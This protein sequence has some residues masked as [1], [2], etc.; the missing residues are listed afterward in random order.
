MP[1]LRTLALLVTCLGFPCSVFEARGE[2]QAAAKAQKY[3]LEY[4]FEA[5]ENPYWEVSH[6]ARI[7]STAGGSTQVVETHSDSTKVWKVESVGPKGEITLVHQVDHVR[8]RCSTSGREETVVEIPSPDGK[9]P[10][11][12]YEQMAED[13]G[14]PLTRLVMDRHGNVID[15]KDLRKKKRPTL[16]TQDAPMTI[17]LPDRAVAVGERWSNEYVIKAPR[18]Q[19]GFKIV[20]FE[21]RFTLKEVSRDIATIAVDNIVLTPVNEPEV[22]AQ[23]AQSKTK[24]TIKFDLV[25]GR[26]IRQDLS[27]DEEVIGVPL[28]EASSMHYVMHFTE[29]YGREPQAA[30]G[31]AKTKVR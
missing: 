19:G 4:K 30:R 29:S 16:T 20:K 15:R 5:G 31:K 18:R 6:Q 17:P 2:D 22:Q 27:L 7:R 11:L 8:M 9:K 10:P 1:R 26:V 24:G 28:G 23:V 13:V 21:Q 12:G 14:V 3:T 25:A